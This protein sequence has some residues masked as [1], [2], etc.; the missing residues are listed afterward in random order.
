MILIETEQNSY[1]DTKMKKIVVT[2]GSGMVGRYMQELYPEAQYPSSKE[3][4]LLDAKQVASYLQQHKPDVVVHLAAAV[5]GIVDNVDNPLTYFED[6]ILMNFNIVRE[7]NQAGVKNFIGISST[8]AYPDSFDHIPSFRYPISE[9]DVHYGP[10][11]PTN[12]G[13]GYA[14]RVLGVHVDV[15]NTTNKH[16]TYCYIYP[17]NLFGEYDKYENSKSHF[18][19]ALLKKISDAQK[20]GSPSIKLLGTGAPLRQFIYGEDLAKLIIKMI[21]TDTYITMNVA[22]DECFTIDALARKTLK[23]LNLEHINIEYSGTLDGQYRKDANN[24]VLKQ[25][26]PNFKFTPFEK[27]IKDTYDYITRYNIV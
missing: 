7:S 9:S 26:F 6:N 2:G 11:T 5:A 20:T 23:A 12:Y 22:P 19:G 10:P 1:Q 27:A 24:V 4:N 25:T 13:Y 16:S 18:I 15:I 8:C 14:K 3:L 17:C 21:K